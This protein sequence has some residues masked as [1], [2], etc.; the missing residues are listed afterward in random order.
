MTIERARE[1]LAENGV[2]RARARTAV[3]RAI[4][5]G[6]LVRPALCSECGSDPGPGSDGRSRIHAHH[7]AGYDKPLVVEWLCY[8]CHVKHDPRVRGVRNVQGRKT[9]CDRGHQFTSANT[10]TSRLGYRICREC[11]RARPR[12]A[13][14]AVRVTA[15]NASGVDR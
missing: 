5:A 14:K 4:E 10:Y 13:E 15:R 1:V 2:E 7:Y 12:V 6:R 3:R 9:H 8:L 11:R